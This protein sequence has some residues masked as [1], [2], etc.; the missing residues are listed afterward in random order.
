M[1][2]GYNRG[3]GVGGG[4]GVTIRGWTMPRCGEGNRRGHGGV[5]GVLRGFTMPRCGE[6]V[7]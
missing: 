7:T 6:G 3:W 4:L 2:E 5:E 1:G